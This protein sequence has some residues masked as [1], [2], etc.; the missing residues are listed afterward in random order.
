LPLGTPEGWFLLARLAVGLVIAGAAF[1]LAFGWTR[2]AALVGIVA[3]AGYAV[4]VPWPRSGLPRQF[5]ADQ[6]PAFM[7]WLATTA[8][9]NDRSFGIFP[10]WSS[11]AQLQDIETVGPL[12][13]PEFV[14]FVGLISDEQTT[15]SY[16]SSTNFML[17]GAWTKYDLGLYARARPILDWAGVR[18]L[19]LNKQLFSSSARRD[20]L[21]LEEPPISL[22]QVY[23]D[24]RVYV[25]A[26]SQAQ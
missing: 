2:L 26:S 10:D 11:I 12:A 25:L 6:Q 18:Y 22:Q 8:T 21:P 7:R 20:A 17:T 14:D 19:V 1:L 4:L 9:A 13:P 5:E 15:Q 24:R 3:V 23:E 16:R